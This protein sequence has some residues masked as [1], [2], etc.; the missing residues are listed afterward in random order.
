MSRLVVTREFIDGSKILTCMLNV[1]LIYSFRQCKLRVTNLEQVA[2]S[3]F[4]REQITNACGTVILQGQHS[5]LL[6]GDFTA[7]ISDLHVT[8]MGRKYPLTKFPPVSSKESL[9]TLLA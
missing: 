2:R 7:L 1:N 5:N 9:L 8:V 3:K 4:Y 6:A